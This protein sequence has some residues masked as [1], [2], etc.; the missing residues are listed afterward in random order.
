MWHGHDP[1]DYLK[2]GYFV[3]SDCGQP[4][5]CWQG[6]HFAWLVGCGALLLFLFYFLITAAAPAYT[7]TLNLGMPFLVTI[8][9]CSRLIIA[10]SAKIV[11]WMSICASLFLSLAGN[12][13]LFIAILAFLRSQVIKLPKCVSFF[14]VGVYGAIVAFGSAAI[15]VFLSLSPNVSFLPQ[16]STQSPYSSP[17]MQT[18]PMGLMIFALCAL[19]VICLL[20]VLWLCILPSRLSR[21]RANMVQQLKGVE[22]TPLDAAAEE[23]DEEFEDDD[24][25][26]DDD[27]ESPEYAVCR[28]H[29]NFLSSER[30]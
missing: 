29:N 1:D 24:Q 4:Y 6:M 10:W 17:P 3:N 25:Y 14:F 28:H 27:D 19:I 13:V 22:G 9:L 18:C 30:C 23:E 11:R 20:A 12:V 8:T 7:G 5:H 2:P 26:Y 21:Q 16:R 15:I